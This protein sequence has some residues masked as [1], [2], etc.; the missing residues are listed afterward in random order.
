MPDT[1]NTDNTKQE[2]DNTQ[3]N[4]QNANAPKGS[5]VVLGCDSNSND[6]LTMDTVAKGLRDAGYDVNQLDIGPSPFSQHAYTQEAKGEI[7]VYLMADSLFS[8]ADGFHDLYAYDVFVVRGGVGGGI[9]SQQDFE[10]KTLGADPDCNSV[11]DEWVGMTYP[12]MNQKAAGKCVAVY[13]GTTPEEALQAALQGL[14]GAGAIAG[15]PTT[16]NTGGGGGAVKIPDVTF[17]GLIRQIIGAIDGVFIIANNLAY[18]LA[19]KDMFK[20]KDENDALIPTIKP[21]DIIYN[22][23]KK[24]WTTAGYY[25]S[26]EVTYSEGTIKYKHDA[27]VEQ[28]GENV[29]YYDC[30]GDDYE[31]AKSKAQAL[32]S[33]HVR[34]YSTDVELQVF[35]NPFITAGSWVKLHKSVV[36][37]PEKKD[38]KKKDKKKKIDTKRKGINITN[39]S[40]EIVRSKEGNKKIY[41]LTDEK[42]EKIDIEEEQ[43]DYDLF[44]VQSYNC[45]WD[46]KHSL[47]MNLHLKY[48]PD[49]P[50]DPVNAT[51]GTGGGNATMGTAAGGLWGNDAFTIADI[52][53][54]N[55]EKILPKYGGGER[56]Q[57]VKEL[58]N[59]KYMPEA[60][61]YQPRANPNS[62]YAKKYSQMKSPAEVYAAFRSE[63]RYSY[64]GDNCECWKSATDFYDNAGKTANCGDTTCLLKVF[65]DCIGVPSC[66]VHIDQHYFNAIQINGTWEIIDGVRIDNQTC[67]FPDGVG[68]VFEQPYPCNSYKSNGGDANNNTDNGA[69]NG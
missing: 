9:N 30:E 32:L 34:D 4:N 69:N 52:C 51:I 3:N 36:Q 19:F 45:K 25:N 67:G 50:E 39:I 1:N 8:F 23:L 42:G 48:G 26:V 55:N 20:Y 24:D 6:T 10:T 60:S 11:C 54:A 29:Y 59:G 46:K 57:E 15:T 68:Y 7:G 12:Q 2:T 66:G 31:T 49:T 58:V 41:H 18:L 33:A 64:Y 65:F 35:Y 17:Y 56:V 37:I 13:G 27:L 22:T 40:E 53:V 16:T 28:Y 43:S 5:K 62:N 21:S 14:T 44:F 61:D 47:I 63:Y 38:K